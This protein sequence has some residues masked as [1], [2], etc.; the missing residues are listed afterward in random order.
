MKIFEKIHDLNICL[1]SI[2][3]ENS[4]I[5]F[6]PTMGALHKGHLSLIEKAKSENNIVVCSI[7]VNPSQFNNKKDLENYPRSIA[8]D[9][10]L[11]NEAGCDIL[12]MPSISEIYPESKSQGASNKPELKNFDFGTLDKVMEGKYRPGHFN[13]VAEV[14]S[15]L[16]NIVKPRNA[17]FGQKDFQ[18]L[19]IVKKLAEQLNFPINIIGCPTIREADGL[20]M[21]SRNIN[22]SPEERKDAVLI[23]QTLFKVKSLSKQYSIDEVKRWA[24][25]EIS[26]NKRMHLEYFEIVDPETLLSIGDW[27][28]TGQNQ[29]LMAVFLG[30]VRLID[31]I[32]F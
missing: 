19:A 27:K 8:N 5:G 16:F 12:F 26:A 24:E 30:K 29:A 15:K 4:V 1:S 7:F 32:I 13:G 2:N 21:S 6:I 18:Q 14:V 25:K 20:A 3:K 17:Y 11:L 9:I 31:N 22:L 23:S 28:G 10:K